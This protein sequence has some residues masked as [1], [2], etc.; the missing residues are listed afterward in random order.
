MAPTSRAAALLHGLYYGIGGGWPLVHLESFERVTG[1][2]WDDWLVRTVG[3]LMVSLAAGFLPASR[4]GASR[5]LQII[6]LLSSASVGGIAAYYGWRRRISRLY[7]LDAAFQFALAALWLRALTEPEPRPTRL[8][9]PRS[10]QRTSAS[11]PAGRS[12]ANGSAVRAQPE[13]R[14]P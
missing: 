1:G 6:G 5:E 3:W 10:A 9:H 12:T 2:K 4:R 14:L 13:R 8:A 7:L 11:E